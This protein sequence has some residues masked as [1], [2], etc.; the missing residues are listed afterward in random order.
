M[1]IAD[2][3]NLLLHG[4][5]IE[6]LIIL[7]EPFKLASV[8]V[9]GKFFPVRFNILVKVITTLSSLR[10]PLGYRNHQGMEMR[11]GLVQ[12]TFKSDSVLRRGGVF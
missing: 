9:L 5:L 1:G 3:W 2:H 7:T 12:M 6:T 8:D 10:H 11:G 4:G